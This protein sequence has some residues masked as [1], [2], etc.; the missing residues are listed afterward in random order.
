MVSCAPKTVFAQPDTREHKNEKNNATAAFGRTSDN[1]HLRFSRHDSNRASPKR[2]GLSELRALH[3]PAR[4]RSL[5]KPSAQQLPLHP[6]SRQVR[7]SLRTTLH[8]PQIATTQLPPNKPSPAQLQSKRS[9]KKYAHSKVRNLRQSRIR[10]NNAASVIRSIV[11][12]KRPE[13]CQRATRPL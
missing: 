8:A 7:C 12:E 10:Q 13:H 1:A 2:S 11:R 5:A 6:S 4:T 3:E 9:V